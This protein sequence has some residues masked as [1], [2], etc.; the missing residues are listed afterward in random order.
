VEY[1]VRDV[2]DDEG[3]KGLEATF[4]VDVPPD[5]LLE[6][7]WSPA[8][9][10]RLFPDVKEARV[11]RGEGDWLEVDFRVDAVL[12]E[13]RYTIRRTIDRAART[14]T[15]REVGG[16]LRRVRGGWR[17]E[18]TNGGAASRAT[19]AAFVDV[20]RVVP[21]RLVRDGAKRKLGEMVERVRRVAVEM[22]RA[23]R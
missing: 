13:V 5:A 22:H 17:L 16:E 4:D 19:Y 7:L 1:A 9:Y 12:K 20:A 23:P 18:P 3:T 21:T 2:T 11:A 8:S 6:I 14:I 10:P 15:W